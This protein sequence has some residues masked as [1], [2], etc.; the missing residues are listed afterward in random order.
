MNALIIE[1]EINAFEYLKALLQKIEPSASI[2]AH[3]DSVEDSINWLFKNE[4]P[5]LLFMDIQL[6][7]GL[8]FEIFNHVEVKTPIIFTTA[9]DQYAIEAF[10][11]NSI[12]YLL[13]PINPEDLAQALQ[14]FNSQQ[15]HLKTHLNQQL[16]SVFANLNKQ[17]KHR[18]LVKRA[19][20]FEF[21]EV[22]DI[23]FVYS[24]NSITF[25]HTFD[26]KRHLYNNTVEGLVKTLD[27]TLFFQI[28]RNQIVNINAIQ[29]I[30]PYFNQ[31]LKLE[32]KLPAEG[33]DFL[34]SRSKISQF[35]EW[36]DL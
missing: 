6:A 27:E 14:K 30:H 34:V 31:R 4:A 13:K 3:L 2:L 21:I 20:H 18:C 10:K 15:G 23:A 33:F 22:V 36:I 28:S 16:Q 29:K 35:K 5:D 17:K 1:D 7:D 19:N 25:L 9:F 24:E 11:V 8:C 32:L 12:D 26:G